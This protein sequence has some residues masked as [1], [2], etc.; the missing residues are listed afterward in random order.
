MLIGL[1]AFCFLATT[2][3]SLSALLQYQLLLPM[4]ATKARHLLPGPCDMLVG[5]EW[6]EAGGRV[7]PDLKEP[8]G[9]WGP[10]WEK[11]SVL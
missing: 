6:K 8:E 11:R 2:S 5:V 1:Q 3:S 4:Y 10:G 9:R 7:I